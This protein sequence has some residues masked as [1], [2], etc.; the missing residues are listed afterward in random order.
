MRP[1]QARRATIKAHPAP[2]HLPRPY[3]L[4]SAFP[5]NLPLRDFVPWTLPCALL[6]LF[7]INEVGRWKFRLFLLPVEYRCAIFPVAG[8]DDF[9]HDGEGHLF[10]GCGADIQAYWSVDGAYLL[11]G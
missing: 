9:G 8:G 2:L 1:D 4:T 11:I 5:K 7:F 6:S 3:G 10:G